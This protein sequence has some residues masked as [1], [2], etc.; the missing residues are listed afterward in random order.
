MTIMFPFYQSNFSHS[1]FIIVSLK[2]FI[3]ILLIAVKLHHYA[4]KA[5]YFELKINWLKRASSWIKILKL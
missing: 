1:V 2:T 3:R 5:D 4:K